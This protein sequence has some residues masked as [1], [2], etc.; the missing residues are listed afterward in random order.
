MKKDL[1][2]FSDGKMVAYNPI[3]YAITKHES[4]FDPF[5]EG[6]KHLKDHAYGIL[7][8]R[9]PVLTDVNETFGTSYTID[10]LV[11]KSKTVG[12][13]TIAVNN[14]IDIYTKQSSC[15]FMFSACTI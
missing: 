14:S 6:D 5:A 12:D 11:P 2:K 13:I 15:T 8:I 9:Q 7:Q 1:L 3:L 4:H 10:D